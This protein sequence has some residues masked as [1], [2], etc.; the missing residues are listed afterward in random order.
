MKA[1]EQ[2]STKGLH[3][4]EVVET[5]NEQSSTGSDLQDRRHGAY[6]S[7]SSND[8]LPQGLQRK[9]KGPLSPTRGR[10]TEASKGKR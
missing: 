3:R 9:P 1:G 5:E 6:D 7:V 2:D 4:R 10:T 8:H